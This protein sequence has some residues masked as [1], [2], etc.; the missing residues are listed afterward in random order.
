M[1]E[2]NFTNFLINKLKSDKNFAEE[3]LK[4]SLE[5]YSEN[6]N[7][8]E[9]M[10]ALRHLAEA[11]GISKLEKK[12]GIPRNVFYRSLAPKGNPTI[13]TLLAILKSLNLK[14]VFKPA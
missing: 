6:A 10:L 7:K 12:S 14:M 8:E 11:E 3:F 1:T 5:E 9:L 4:V 13:D 2:Q